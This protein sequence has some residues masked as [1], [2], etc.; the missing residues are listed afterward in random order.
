MCSTLKKLAN[1]LQS[2]EVFQILKEILESEKEEYNMRFL[3]HLL[4]YAEN[5]FGKEVIGRDYREREDGQRISN[6]EVD[7][8]IFHEINYKMF[9][10]F[11][12]N[13]SISDA[14]RNPYYERSIRLLSLWLVHYDSD[15]SD[16]NNNLRNIRIS[17]V[18]R[19]LYELE[20]GMA[21]CAINISQLDIAEEHIRLGLSYSRRI[22]VEDDDRAT[23]V[24]RMLGMYTNLRQRQGDYVGALSF[25]EEGYNLVVDAYDPAHKEVQVC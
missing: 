4:S 11:L 12:L 24:F 17:Y 5:K 6:W 1:K 20:R 13:E 3:E 7:I 16:N 8:G 19:K 21:M 23:Y 25:A 22:G 9:A 2:I 15:T 10:S 18:S 14:I